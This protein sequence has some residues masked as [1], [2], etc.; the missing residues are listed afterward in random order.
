MTR[1]VPRETQAERISA[2]VIR[3]I[4][5]FGSVEALAKATGI[6]M[7]TIISWQK[8]R[9]QE[10]RV[11][12][13]AKLVRGLRRSGV[14]V[15]LEYLQTGRSSEDDLPPVGYESLRLFLEGVKG[16]VT[17]QEVAF[18]DSLDFGSEG[19]VVTVDW[20]ASQLMLYRRALMTRPNAQG[21]G[22]KKTADAA[23]RKHP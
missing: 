19:D 14:L 6:T 7:N 11:G 17:L 15:S 9:V 5:A 22:A 21:E 16:Q 2:V 23:K 1:T 13:L 20:W 4:E 12:N 3:G 8:K 10:F 18:L